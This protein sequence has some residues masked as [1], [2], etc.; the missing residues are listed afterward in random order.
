M[1]DV[2][3]LLAEHDTALAIGDDPARPFQ[4][5]VLTTDWTF[6]RFHRGRRGRRGNYSETEISFWAARLNGWCREADVYAY[7][8][9]DREAF[10]VN[11]A[12][13]LRAAMGLGG[14]PEARP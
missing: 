13:A 3:S 12:L 9:N 5:Y 2:Y 1:P 4:A 7:F 6:V 14:P 8:N 10:A 11:N